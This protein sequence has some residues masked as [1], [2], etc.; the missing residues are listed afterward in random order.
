MTTE[1]YI[2]LIHPGESAADDE[3]TKVVATV[4]PTGRD[5]FQAAAVNGY[6]AEYMLEVWA[7]EYDDQ[8]EV[9]FNGKRLTIYR[10]YPKGERTELYAAERIGNNG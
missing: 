5:E 1:A 8:P 6:H 10:T 9:I 3:E 2:T 4:N 7:E